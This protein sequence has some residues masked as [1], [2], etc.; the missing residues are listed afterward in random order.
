MTQH[1]LQ[2]QLDDLKHV[3]EE[4]QGII[5]VMA[6]KLHELSDDELR[7]KATQKAD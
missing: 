1:K 5:L 6:N 3:V 7:K 4:L 2:Q